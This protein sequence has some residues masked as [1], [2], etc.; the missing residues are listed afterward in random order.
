MPVDSPCFPLYLLLS[1][2]TLEDRNI[3]YSLSNTMLCAETTQHQS[4]SLQVGQQ[5]ARYLNLKDAIHFSALQSVVPFLLKVPSDGG[6]EEHAGVVWT[7]MDL[8]LGCFV[9]LIYA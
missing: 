7:C 2:P 8:M 9:D 1:E 3:E 5:H 6:S 4:I